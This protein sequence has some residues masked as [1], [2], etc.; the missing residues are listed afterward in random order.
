[1]TFNLN[2]KDRFLRMRSFMRRRLK[3]HILGVFH[4]RGFHLVRD[5]FHIERDF[6]FA[7]AL[8]SY[9]AI[10]KV[11]DVGAN[12]GQYAEDIRSQGYKGDIISFEPVTAAFHELEKRSR[13]DIHWITRNAGLSDYDGR[14]TINVSNDT[15]FSSMLDPLPNLTKA[16]PESAHVSKEQVTVHKLDSIFSEYYEAGDKVLLKIDAQGYENKILEGASRSLDNI[17]GVQLELS[18][19]LNYEGALPIMEMVNLLARKGYT[20]VL[21]EPL[22]H[23]LKLNDLSEADGMFFRLS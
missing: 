3:R 19:M 11:L 7:P 5:G 13:N 15:S 14:A 18:L 2:A 16:Y 9:F 8:R 1:M 22:Q 12:I 17:I 10:N 6:D 4:K 20:L 23:N 21:L